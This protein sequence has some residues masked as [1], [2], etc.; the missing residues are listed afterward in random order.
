MHSRKYIYSEEYLRIHTMRYTE[1]IPILSNIQ[2]YK[3]DRKKKHVVL[4]TL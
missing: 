2:I 3:T 4:Y 1:S